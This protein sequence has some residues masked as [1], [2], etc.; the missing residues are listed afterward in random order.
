MRVATLTPWYPTSNFIAFGVFV[1]SQANELAKY[2]DVDILL[3]ERGFPSHTES[4]QE[5]K[6]TVHK[7]TCFFLPNWREFLLRIWAHQY[8][9]LFKELHKKNKYDIIHCHDLF[10]SYA[11]WYI[12]QK[13]NIPYV[14]T[15]HNSSI[16]NMT[17]PKW[18]K[19]YLPIVLNNASQTIA[20]G[21]KLGS[22]LEKNFTSN[23]IIVL[24]NVV[25]N[26]S[27]TPTYVTK[28]LFPF[29]FL[30][31]GDLDENKGVMR[32]LK[33][34]H[35]MEQ[36]RVKLRVIGRGPLMDE[37]KRF[38]RDNQLLERV[39]IQDYVS[40]QDLPKIYDNSHAYVSLSLEETFGITILEAMSCALPVIYTKS[41]GPDRMIAPFG[42]IE[43]SKTEIDKI[44]NSMDQMIIEYPQVDRGAIRKHVLDNFSSKIVI[45]QLIGIL[46]QHKIKR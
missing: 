20:V 17:L 32:L 12:N 24:P 9:L 25:D 26:D 46:D 2:C 40:N 6:V 10:G 31:I 18:Q 21:D 7:K 42:C 27:F 19:K 43:T 3:L 4:E 38:I 44:S 14:T 34:F 41:G 15:M 29:K 13:M 23:K 39:Q 1:Q 28:A 33:A 11:G 30:F 5:G 16:Q 37:A 36:K 35:K 22:V 45:D 8:Y